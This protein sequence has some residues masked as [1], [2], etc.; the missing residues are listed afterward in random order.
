MQENSYSENPDQQ[1]AQVPKDPSNLGVETGQCPADE[2]E[3]AAEDC[4]G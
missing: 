2:Q 3:Q 1:E 4:R